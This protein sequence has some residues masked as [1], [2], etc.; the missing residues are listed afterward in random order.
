VI[1]EDAD[2]V[3]PS[4]G[5]P[6]IKPSAVSIL[7]DLGRRLQLRDVEIRVGGLPLENDRPRREKS[8]TKSGDRVF[9]ARIVQV[10]GF[11]LS[12]RNVPFSDA[13]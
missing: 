2:I 7:L 5:H 4:L 6:E 8:G 1:A 11:R 12:I 10:D 9:A 13:T 3:R